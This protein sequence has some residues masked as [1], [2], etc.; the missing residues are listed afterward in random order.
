MSELQCVEATSISDCASLKAV[1]S[2]HAPSLW[3]NPFEVTRIPLG[4]VQAEILPDQG[5]MPV[6]SLLCLLLD[7]VRDQ[8]A[9]RVLLVA[10]EEAQAGLCARMF[11]SCEKLQEGG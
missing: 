9:R 3:L 11:E 2:G 8:A 5:D 7:P 1:K 6:L 4:T 10:D